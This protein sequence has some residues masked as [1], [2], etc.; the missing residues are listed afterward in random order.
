[1]SDV[2]VERQWTWAM[3]NQLFEQYP[4]K[5]DELAGEFGVSVANLRDRAAQL[6]VSYHDDF[7]EEEEALFKKYGSKLKGA[8]LFLMPNRSPC[9][10]MAHL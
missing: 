9:E 8:M 4:F 6:G 1:M 3:Y 2:K 7:T 10:I 5:G